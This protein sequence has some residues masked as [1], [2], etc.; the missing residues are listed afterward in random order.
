MEHN[1]K[2][3]YI[4]EPQKITM[5]DEPIPVI[6]EPD[7]VIIKVHYV[8]ICGSDIHIFEGKNPFVVYP[9]VFGHEFVG[10]VYAVGENVSG[11]EVGNHVVGEPIDYCGS[12]YACRNGH[13]NVC[14]HLQVYGVHIN[15]GCQN[16][17]KMPAKR[18]HKVCGSVPMEY[19]VLAEPLTIG[20]RSCN[21]AQVLAGDVVLVQ[22]SGTI[23]LCAMLAAKAKGATV[24]ITDL[25]DEKLAFAKEMGADYTLNARNVDIKE[26]VLKITDGSGPNVILDAVGNAKSL[27]DAIDMASVAG[28]IVELGMSAITSPVSHLK[29]CKRDLA[30]LGTRLQAY[31]FP[32]AIAYLEANWQSLTAFITDI[33]PIEAVDSAFSRVLT[34]PGEVRKILIQLS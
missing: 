31:E 32:E 23:G 12:C 17:I 26:E 24:I 19:A 6:T 11:L 16:Y 29:L 22:G 21:R 25:Y 9:R 10:E 34:A 30:L 7:D 27:E 33:Y 13:P 14:E 5:R 1:M 4:D 2:A 20:F 28:R 18:V 15:G 3:A 8:G